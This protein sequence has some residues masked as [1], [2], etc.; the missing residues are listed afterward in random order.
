MDEV[1]I[2][3]I[4]SG[5]DRCDPKLERATACFGSSYGRSLLNSGSYLQLPAGGYRRF[6]PREVANLLGFPPSFKVP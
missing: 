4:E 5:I 6:S 1:A 2:A 3:S